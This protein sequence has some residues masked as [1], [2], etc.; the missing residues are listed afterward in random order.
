M[1]KFLCLFFNLII[2]IEIVCVINKTKNIF[3]KG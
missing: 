3:K 2:N 1:I